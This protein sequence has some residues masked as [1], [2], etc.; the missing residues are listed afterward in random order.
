MLVGN[1]LAKKIKNKSGNFTR[2]IRNFILIIGNF[3]ANNR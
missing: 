3:A 2:I 1:Y